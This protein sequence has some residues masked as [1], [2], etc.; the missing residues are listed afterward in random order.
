MGAAFN[1]QTA[2]FTKLDGTAALTSQ[3]ADHA[4]AAGKKAIYDSVPQPTKPE[5]KTAFPYVVVGDET[6]EPA[7]TDD[8][9]A[10]ETVID[11]HTFTRYKGKKELKNIMDA[12]KAALHD[13]S[14]TVT[15]EKFVF[16]YWE[17]STT[18]L[19][20]DGVT[21]HGVQRFRLYTEGT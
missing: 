18:A 21:H 10:R 4:F 12:I 2:V 17:F 14:L 6:A 11:I 16:C 9:D 13:A 3:L 19:E 8:A 20:P 5:L 7:D 15:G 1:I